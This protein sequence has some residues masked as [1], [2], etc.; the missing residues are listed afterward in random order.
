MFIETGDSNPPKRKHKASLNILSGTNDP[1]M[2]VD[3]DNQNY[4]FLRRF[5]ILVNAQTLLWPY[6]L[7][8][9]VMI[10]ITCFP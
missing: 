9:V 6:K 8:K 4:I 10:E 2:V 7:K 1:N 5:T 3:L